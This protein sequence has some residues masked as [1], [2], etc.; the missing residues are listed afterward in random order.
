MK[1]KL[2]ISLLVAFFG[3]TSEKKTM[4]HPLDKSEA[5]TFVLENGL[6]VYLLSDPSFNL[7]AASVSVEVGSYEDPVDREGLSHFLEHMLFLGTEKYP[8]V[9]EYST[10]L[11]TNGGMSN[12]YT[13]RDHTNYQFQVLPDAFDGA[14]DR[15]S[16]FFIGPLFTE[17]YTAREVNAVNSEY[18]KN[19]MSDGWRQFRMNGLFANE[20]PP[21]AKFNIGNL[22]TL[23]DIDRMELIDFYREHYSANRMGLAMLS[24]HSL[25]E[26]E[27]WARKHFSAV[28]NH[29]LPRNVHDSNIIEGK[30]TL[31]VVYV[32]PVK[33]IRKMDILFELP[34]TRDKYESK[35]GRQFGF[36]L[37][38]EGKGSLL[39]HLKQ[40]GWALTLSAGT[41]QESKEVGLATVSIGLTEAG[42]KQYKDVLKSVVGYIQLMKDSGYQPHVFN[43]LSSMASLNEIYSSKG[44]G[45]WRA[46]DLANEAMMYPISDVGRINYIYRD[47]KPGSYNNLLSQLNIENMMVYLSSKG[48]PTDKT[49]HFFQINY[50]YTEDDDLYKELS[51]PIIYDDFMVAEQNPFIPKKASVPKRELAEDVFP[52]PIIDKSGV[53]LYFGE[54]HEFLRPKGVIGLKIMLP[55]D[56]MSIQHRVYSRLYAACVKESLN[57]LSYPAKQAGLNYNIRDSYEGILLDVNGY[58]E[59]AMKLYELMLDHMV[60]FSVTD[61]QF[62]AIKD[63]IVRDYENFALSD[64]HQQTRE[65]SSDVM[66]GIKYTWEDALPVV[67]ESSLKMLKEYSSSLYSK[68]FVE[69]MVYG[70][71]KETDARKAVQLFNRKTNTKSIERSQAFDISYLQFSGPETIQYTNE[72][73]VNNSCFFRKYYIGED[74]P[75]TRAVSNII[76]KSIQQPFYTEMRTNQQ[77][78]YIV[79]SYARSLDESYYLNFL[80]QS[81]VYPADELDKRANAFIDTAPEFLREMDQETYQQLID[82][83]IEELEKKPMSISER[84]A[85][86]KTLIFEHEADYKRDQKTIEALRALDKDF[87]VSYLERVLSKDSRKMVNVLS[88]AEG[89]EN[90]TKAKNSFGELNSW[91]ASRVYE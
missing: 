83:A 67:K 70:D 41:R 89:H 85:K 64:A 17:E 62:D 31:R 2:A 53:K 73:L 48:V 69:A 13:A 26:M 58:K 75:E 30:K 40:K 27:Q 28:E 47:D 6:K 57:E 71:F 32:E 63:K 60:D 66:F 82:S 51:T 43:E 45:M 39:S 21:A 54:D 5:R 14:L 33:D 18:Q 52:S 87:L 50:S 19:I 16:Q 8:D 44:E 34:S 86:L 36:I 46:T 80:I 81:G 15:F 65:L 38:H 9:D 72:L 78:G 74:S 1:N 42:L 49:E 35:P 84:A 61:E 56:K 37:G 90:K 88:F 77:L 4:Q 3:C 79:W 68:T 24:T 59:S 7:S 11:K 12:A 76:S 55:K 10:Y 20:S 23:G 22:E 91:K 25:D 29:N